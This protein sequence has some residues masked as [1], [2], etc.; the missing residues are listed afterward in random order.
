M[1]W[2][3]VLSWVMGQPCCAA[4]WD[5]NATHGYIDMGNGNNYDYADSGEV[6]MGL[7]MVTAMDEEKEYYWNVGT[8]AQ[9]RT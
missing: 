3:F 7:G 2:S 5:G 6:G 1:R 9:T 8:I 4:V